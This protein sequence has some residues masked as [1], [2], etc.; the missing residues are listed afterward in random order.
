MTFAMIFVNAG[1]F[2]VFS[3]LVRFLYIRSNFKYMKSLTIKLLSIIILSLTLSGCEKTH[4]VSKSQDILYQV[5]YINYAWVYSHR[6]LYI[7]INGNI[8]TYN[9]PEKW[10]F[11][12]EDQLLT[13]KEVLEN[14]AACKISGK[15]IPGEELQKYI[16]Y[17][18]NI[19]ASKVTSPKYNAA[20]DAGTLSYYCYQYSESSSTY[21]RTIIRTE[22][23][24]ECENLNF[25]TKK[26]VDWMNDIRSSIK[27]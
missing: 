17:I 18:D 23:D 2:S 27:K 8:L 20:S 1:H 25:F 10:N 11:P 7:D 6:G 22:G 9:L 5:E 19:A 14:I 15:K 12:K 3:R 26:I 4:V 24:S 13:R 21:K 16:K